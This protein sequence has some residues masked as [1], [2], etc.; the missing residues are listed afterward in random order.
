MI[1]D[2]PTP[3]TGR[4]LNDFVGLD[5][6]NCAI[7]KGLITWTGKINCPSQQEICDRGDEL[8]ALL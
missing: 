1:D 5:K 6:C 2:N 8:L 3:W 7:R 4:E